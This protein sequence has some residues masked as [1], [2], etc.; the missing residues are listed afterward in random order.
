MGRARAAARA[1][2]AHRE[3]GQVARVRMMEA[4]EAEMRAF[5]REARGCATGFLSSC[6]TSGPGL[7]ARHRLRG[8][9]PLHQRGARGQRHRLRRGLLQHSRGARRRLEGRL[10]RPAPDCDVCGHCK[11]APRALA[12]GR[13]NY[14]V[15][16]GNGRSDHCPSKEANIVFARDGSRTRSRARAGRS[17][18]RGLLRLMQAW[19]SV[20]AHGG[21]A[22][23]GPGGIGP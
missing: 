14:V 1:R 5:V 15:Y 10:P 21:K 19:D 23:G 9:G 12:Q 6:R 8:P 2:R 3:G 7:P 11:L 4:T 17:C 13:R 22:Q 18:C 16:I 20:L